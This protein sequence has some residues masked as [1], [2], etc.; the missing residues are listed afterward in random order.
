ME[1]G[2]KASKDTAENII[3]GRFSNFDEFGNL[4]QNIRYQAGE[5][6]YIYQ[7]DDLG[8]LTNWDAEEL[9]LTERN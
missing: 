3:R 8:R 5:F 6:E 4:R 1:A 7:T 2:G 9:H